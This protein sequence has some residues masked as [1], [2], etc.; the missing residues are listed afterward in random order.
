[1]YVGLI[2]FSLYLWQQVFV[3]PDMPIH[4]VFPLNI[5]AAVVMAALSYHFVELPFLRLKDRPARRAAAA[6]LQAAAD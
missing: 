4:V 5:V 6:G 1:M 3:N 2:S